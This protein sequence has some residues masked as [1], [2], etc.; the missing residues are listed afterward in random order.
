MLRWIE[1]VLALLCCLS[2]P[3]FVAW[4]SFQEYTTTTCIN[5]RCS[6]VTHS[7]AQDNPALLFAIIVLTL[8][9][10][11][12]PAGIIYAH[13]WTT[14]GSLLA[15]MWVLVPVLLICVVGFAFTWMGIIAFFWGT[16]MLLA[17]IV[18]SIRRAAARCSSGRGGQKAGALT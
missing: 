1:R 15:A 8:A 3:A 18:G 4:I 2:G 16:S 10:G 7:D 6:A 13:S 12:A 9:L 14:S 11:L 5:G 17:A